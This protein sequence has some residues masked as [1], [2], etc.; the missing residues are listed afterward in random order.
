MVE[1]KR[2][3]PFTNNRLEKKW[4]AS[5]L[6]R[7][8]I[9]SERTPQNLTI[10][11]ASVTTNQLKDWFDEVLNYLK[12]NEYADTLKDPKR[13]FNAD[14]TVFFLNP[15]GDKVLVAHGEKN[16]YKIVN[17]D[18]KECLTVLITGNTAGD[19]APPMIIFK[20][21]RI[22]KELDKSIPGT[23]EIGKSESG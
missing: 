7:N 13:I 10:T 20:Y 8:V 16:V 5:F 3:N 18:E 15:K 6:K 9:T 2:D 11:R 17:S 14:E 21:E 22:P 4:Y 23:W 12:E 1:L 19:L